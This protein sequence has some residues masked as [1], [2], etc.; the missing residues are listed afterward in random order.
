MLRIGEFCR[1]CFVTK[2]TLRHY[3]EIGLLRPIH[4]AENGYR[5]YGVEQLRD[6]QLIARL[7]GYGFSLEEIKAQMQ[8]RD[9]DSLMKALGEKRKRMQQ[10]VD[11]ISRMLAQ[12]DTDMEKL[13]R[14]E[15]ILEQKIAVKTV[16]REPE[17]IYGVRKKI[18][19]ADFQTLFVE[20]Y[21][22]MAE[23]GITPLGPPRA[24]YHDEDFNGEKADVEVGV[25]VAGGTTEARQLPG[26]LH[27]VTT[28]V[29][30]YGEA[31]YAPAYAALMEWV[32]KNGYAITGPPFDVYV[33]GG[34]GNCPPEENVTEIYAP[35]GKR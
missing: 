25:P 30:P 15:D 7:K 29:G 18:D 20:L 19:V 28:V 5:Y 22:G 4:M 17:W 3:D 21:Q 24:F 16:E 35:I 23:K 2:K 1:I 34:D 13:K 26:G 10:E 11:R 27:L 8:L 6:M 9:E 32:E 31:L 12:M 14:S 33:K